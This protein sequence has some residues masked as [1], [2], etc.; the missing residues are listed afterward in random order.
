MAFRKTLLPLAILGALSLGAAACGPGEYGGIDVGFGPPEAHAEVSVQSPG[1]GYY[2]VP[3]YYDWQ[4]GNYTWVAGSWTRPPHEGDTWVAPR[5][6]RHGS[7]YTY[8]RGHWNGQRDNGHR[9]HD[10]DHG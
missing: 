5:Y 8:Y 9:D 7:R 2:W 10:R 6:E 4:G 1:E 3:G